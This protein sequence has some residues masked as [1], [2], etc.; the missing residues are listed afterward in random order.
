MFSEI[1]KEERLRDI[2][3]IFDRDIESD[4]VKEIDSII[5]KVNH[6]DINS[7]V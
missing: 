5:K 3:K 1:L 2:I 4:V 7:I 6:E